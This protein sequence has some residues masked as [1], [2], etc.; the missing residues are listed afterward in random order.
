[1]R[2]KDI[3]FAENKRFRRM[4]VRNVFKP[5]SA[6]DFWKQMVAAYGLEDTQQMYLEFG[7]IFGHFLHQ[8]SARSTVKLVGA[9]AQTD[10]LLREH[11]VQSCQ[12]STHTFPESRQWGTQRGNTSRK[13]TLRF[14]SHLLIY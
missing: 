5:E 8:H 9:F 10:F 12:R 7:K 14:Q 2:G 13:R 11:A 6:A 3:I 1:M 4:V